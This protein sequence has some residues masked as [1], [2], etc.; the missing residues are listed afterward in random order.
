LNG[1][2]DIVLMA[3]YNVIDRMGKKMVRQTLQ[4]GFGIK[5]ATGNYRFDESNTEHVGNSNFQSGTGSTDYMLNVLYALRYKNFAF[6]SGITYK[7]NTTNKDG[8]K[9]GNRI[10]NVTQVKYVK[11]IG[12]FSIIPS[13]GVM[14]E[15]MLE[16]MHDQVKIDRNRTGGYNIQALL[17]MDINTKQWALGI[18]YS[19]SIKQNLAAGQ[20]HSMPGLNVHLSYSL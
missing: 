10:L 8:Y 19:T 12:S 6:S 18:N 9:F 16:D 3:N 17:G 7:I 1:L 11:D 13:F 2:G 15:Q 20:I 4:T 14:A 5:L